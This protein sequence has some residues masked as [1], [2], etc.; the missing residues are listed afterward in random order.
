MRS[1]R[2]AVAIGVLAALLLVISAT[3]TPSAAQ[4]VSGEMSEAGGIAVL[5]VWG[6][7][8]DMG[9]AEGWFLGARIKPTI[10]G[11]ILPTIP[12]LA[13]EAARRAYPLLFEAAPRIDDEIAGFVD[14][15]TASGA[16]L[17]VE[18]LGRA[19]DV[20]DL[21]TANALAD[22][23][24]ASYLPGGGQ[25]CSSF[26][27]FGDATV[28]SEL[29]GDLAITRNLDWGG[30]SPDPF[31]LSRNTMLVVRIPVEPEY[32]P[33]VAITYP[34]F[35]GCLSCINR[36]GVGA[37]LNQGNNRPPFKDILTGRPYTPVCYATRA[38]VEAADLDGDG[39]STGADV[40]AALEAH[41]FGSVL[42]HVVEPQ[43]LEDL[44][45]QVVELQTDAGWAVRVPSDEPDIGPWRLALTNH[46][47]KLFPPAP[48]WRYDIM[49]EQVQERGGKFDPASLWGLMG[50]VAF[51]DLQHG[52]FT[53]H[54]LMYV[55]DTGD[56]GLAKT[57]EAGFSVDKQPAWFTV[58]G[59]ISPE[60]PGDDDTGTGAAD[61]GA[62]H[63]GG[64]AG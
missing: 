46:D 38:G 32:Q 52:G 60:A 53:N 58:Q 14:G 23:S 19:L 8:Y 1:R 4:G 35:F 2:V 36:A 41:F 13:W 28:D 31:L 42:V 43:A 49:R 21:K 61:H 15:A 27:A 33:T 3:A 51:R 20:L 63:H 48:C 17:F 30:G 47:R 18:E 56:L 59:L 5:R 22:L 37:F 39:R 29:G 25:L 54:T 45:A 40:V 50:M 64:C 10:T 11:Y 34:G 57:D 55:P 6:T 12:P 24:S 44:P 16:D 62:R 26:S 7:A 9:Y